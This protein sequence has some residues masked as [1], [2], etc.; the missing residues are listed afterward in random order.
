MVMGKGDRGVREQVR[1]PGLPQARHRPR[2]RTFSLLPPFPPFGTTSCDN[3]GGTEPWRKMV[4]CPF[5]WLRGWC[6]V[7]FVPPLLLRTLPCRPE[8]VCDTLVRIRHV[9]A[10]FFLQTGMG[11]VFLT[12]LSRLVQPLK[13]P[14]QTTFAKFQPLT[15]PA[16]LDTRAQMQNLFG[17]KG[18]VRDKTLAKRG[19]YS[20]SLKNDLWIPGH[21]TRATDVVEE[22]LMCKLVLVV[23]ELK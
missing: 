3:K 13:I 16:C 23:D 12:A 9:Y 4:Q 19:P 17:R 18:Q 21:T 10:S 8:G 11:Q 5:P 22:G 7:V 14:F 15:T 1:L 20:T 2:G 6:L